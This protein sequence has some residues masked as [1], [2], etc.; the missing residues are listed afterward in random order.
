MARS[1]C[2]SCNTHMLA[3]WLLMI[4]V[5]RSVIGLE[6]LLHACPDVLY[7]LLGARSAVRICSIH[8]Q[9]SDVYC[10]CQHQCI[11]PCLHLIAAVVLSLTPEHVLHKQQDV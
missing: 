4:T 9:M 7:R 2:L 11:D 5:I 1:N 8:V 6:S 3:A 10:S